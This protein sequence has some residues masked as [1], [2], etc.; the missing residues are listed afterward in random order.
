MSLTLAAAQATQLQTLRSADKYA[1][2]YELMETWT[3]DSADPDVK[4]VHTWL[5]GAA[6]I[7][8]GVGPFAALVKAYNQRE[9]L[10]RGRP[11][12]DAD[13][14]GASNE[15]ARRVINRAIDNSAIPNFAEI[16]NFD[17]EGGNPAT[18]AS[19]YIRFGDATA[20][21]LTGDRLG[22]RLYGGA[23]NDTLEGQGCND[24]LEGGS[25]NDIATLSDRSAIDLVA[26]N[27]R[28]VCRNGLLFRKN[29]RTEAKLAC[30]QRQKHRTNA[31]TALAYPMRLAGHKW[32]GR[33]MDSAGSAFACIAGNASNSARSAA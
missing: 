33:R 2:A 25:G 1:E 27:A 10:L 20:N 3:R 15:I 28:P 12:T 18:L 21:T 31:K 16:I 8:R 7:N 17:A 9:G 11:V 13:N 14:Q 5:L 22:D 32:L 19:H 4:L 30:F 29:V 6:D 24:Y 26:R 23:G